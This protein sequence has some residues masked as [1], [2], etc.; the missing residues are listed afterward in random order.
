MNT[1]TWHQAW[2]MPTKFTPGDLLAVENAHPWYSANG[3]LSA[4]IR[5]GQYIDTIHKP[6]VERAAWR[7]ACWANHIACVTGEDGTIVEMLA[8]GAT[9]NHASKYAPKTFA[10]ISPWDDPNPPPQSRDAAVAYWNWLAKN[11]TKYGFFSLPAD[12]LMFIT[13]LQIGFSIGDRPVC[14]AAAAAGLGL[15]EWRTN[16]IRVTPADITYR[17]GALKP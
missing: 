6:K 16:P 3:C 14:S 1:V 17:Y 5:T 12:A 8:G 9:V 15:M 13:G 10:V 7:A 11:K 2:D 4:A